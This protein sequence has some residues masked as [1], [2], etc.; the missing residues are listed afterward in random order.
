M[1][2]EYQLRA[3]FFRTGQLSI[4]GR[5]AVQGDPGHNS[6]NCLVYYDQGGGA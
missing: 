5:Y 2:E 1:Y 3:F 6:S 4:N